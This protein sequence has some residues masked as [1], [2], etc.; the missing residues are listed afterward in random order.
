MDSLHAALEQYYGYSAFLPYQEEIVRD[1]L[2]K[3]DVLAVL[4]TGGG[5]SLCYQL[6]A[7][8]AGGLTVVVSPLISLMKDQVDTLAAQGVAA[9]T[10][11]SSLPYEA[12]VRTL[13]DLEAGRVRLLYVSPEKAVQP[14]FLETLRELRVTLFAIDEAH[15]IS[16]W[17]HQFRPEYRRLRVL[18]EEFP[19]IPVIALT[20]TAIPTVRQDIQRQLDL[21]DPAVYVGSFDRQNLQYAVTGKKGGY[22]R[23]LDYLKSNP[24]RS[25][26]VYFSSRKRTEEVAAKL[27][28]DGIR[29]LPYHA[30]LPAAFRGRVQDLF[31]RDEIDVVCATNAFGMGIDKPDVRFVIHYDMPRSLEAYAQESGRAGRDG[32]ESDC[33]LFYSPGD[34]QKNMKILE[35]DAVTDPEYHRIALQKL[36]AMVQYCETTR[37]RRQYLLDYFGEAFDGVPCN[38]CDACLLPNEFIDGREAAE[39]IVACIAGMPGSFGVRQIADVLAGSR[40]SRVTARGHQDLPAYNSGSEYSSE[41]WSTFIRELVAN[42]CLDQSP[43]QYPVVTLN[44]RSRRILAGDENVRLTRP[45]G[46][47]AASPVLQD[48][49]AGQPD[50]ALFEDLRR[51]RKS[52]ADEQGV[53][54]YVVFPDRTLKEMAGRR[55]QTPEAFAAL[56]GVGAAK[57][58]KYAGTFLAAIRN[59][60]GG[61]PLP[62]GACA[63]AA[64]GRPEIDN[65]P[66][67]A[68]LEEAYA[69]QEHIRKLRE[70]IR[71]A[72]TL[73]RALLERAR[74][75]GVSEN[76]AYSVT[77][78]VS[79]SR[80][81]VPERF[82]E[83]Y[84]EVFVRI[85]HV[86]VGAAE[87]AIGEEIPE[88]CIRYTTSE[89]VRVVRKASPEDGA[90]DR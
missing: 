10:L 28:E 40:S 75:A 49:D 21:A 29:A 26:I 4:A 15:C 7:L 20:A 43:G 16:E 90:A 86:P 1:I 9:A 6:P 78:S 76:E 41:Q 77:A 42:G 47:Q 35:T 52:L 36:T 88:E 14:R 89:S 59:A 61:E 65:V 54:P 82:Y 55:P 56:P 72:D 50:T 44:E 79:R 30:D 85:A 34:R 32:E 19:K 46:Q 66:D 71:S 64:P 33:I 22:A 67:E 70:E 83:R 3:R 13:R 45:K 8:V 38:S 24:G 23:L 51:L 87:E 11:N 31:I 73:R 27:Q 62:D 2:R 18:K 60:S 80:Q 5:K 74:S 17:G 63:P 84:P 39:K 57:L 37:C 68:L 53:P 81:I 69:L 25:G 12:M 48:R 58:E